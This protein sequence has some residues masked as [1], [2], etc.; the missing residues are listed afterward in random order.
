M[1]IRLQKP[2][3]TCFPLEI[4]TQCLIFNFSVDPD[5][6]RIQSIDSHADHLFIQIRAFAILRLFRLQKNQWEIRNSIEIDHVGFCNSLLLD[7]RLLTVSTDKERV[8]VLC[9][10]D[11]DG[12]KM[13]DQSVIGDTAADVMPMHI[14]RG[15]QGEVLIG[16]EDGR[17]AIFKDSKDSEDSKQFEC[18][19]LVLIS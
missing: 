1:K 11:K 19:E 7:G 18:Y 12:D 3:K 9:W 10:T 2:E 6:R 17:L 5:H 8:P 14:T 16:M 13:I 4:L 15:E